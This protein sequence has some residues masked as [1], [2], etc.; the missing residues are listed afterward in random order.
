MAGSRAT[1]SSRRPRPKSRGAS[2]RS[3]CTPWGIENIYSDIASATP[4]GSDTVT[5]TVVTS[6]GDFNIPTT[7]DA[8]AAI[9]AANAAI[10]NFGDGYD[11]VSEPYTEIFTGVNGLP[12][13]DVAEEGSELYD[14]TNT[15]GTD[16]GSFDA[17]V[18]TTA[19]S[20]GNSTQAILV[21]SDVSG[22][23]GAAAGDV[24]AVGSEFDTVTFGDTG[25]E[26][27]YSELIGATSRADL[28]TE[29]L[30]TPTGDITVPSTF[31]AAAALATDILSGG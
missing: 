23:E 10:I 30:V 19:D 4:G 9:A 3:H 12:P 27:I 17:D 16:V 28:V 21:T 13:I 8:T 18:T 20:Y 7:F 25:Y 14:L 24:P 15:A 22:T 31:D 2:G 1:H 11:F 5:D 26:L 6:T 29:T